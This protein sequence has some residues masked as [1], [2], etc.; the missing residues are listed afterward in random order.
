[1][2]NNCSAQS[3]ASD[4]GRGKTARFTLIELLVVIAIIAILAA[5]LLPALSSAR[6]AAQKASCMSNLKQVGISLAGYEGE[7][8]R[9]PVAFFLADD[10]SARRWHPNY[11]WYSLLYAVNPKKNKLLQSIYGDWMH[12]KC[13]AD[14]T[15]SESMQAHRK[16]WRTYEANVVAMPQY[17]EVNSSTG[18]VDAWYPA[19][20]NPTYGL[21]SKIRN[22]PSNLVTIMEYGRDGL[23]SGHTQASS[24]FHLASNDKNLP[25]TDMSHSRFFHPTGSNYLMWDGH[26][27]H[28]DR[29]LI[30]GFDALY[31]NNKT[32]K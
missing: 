6:N 20:T 8:G 19:G 17:T 30:S 3:S 24:A 28:L 15:R 31:I 32:N 9:L 5:I 11:S 10:T 22:S 12:L 21:S 25:I 16:Y 27:E 14:N 13:P 29:L 7:H 2:E 1:M 23:R 4:C 18:A 26:V